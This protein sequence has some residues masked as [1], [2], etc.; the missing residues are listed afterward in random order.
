L[1]L[2]PTRTRSAAA[3]TLGRVP[4]PLLFGPLVGFISSLGPAKLLRTDLAPWRLEPY[5]NTAPS[6]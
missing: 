1:L 3:R 2:E 4:L 5:S 6:R